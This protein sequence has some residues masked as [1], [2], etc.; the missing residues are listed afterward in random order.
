MGVLIVSEALFSLSFFTFLEWGVWKIWCSWRGGRGFGWR[1]GQGDACWDGD[2][3][4]WSADN[5]FVQLMK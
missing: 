2:W 5:E 4:D 1:E 3:A